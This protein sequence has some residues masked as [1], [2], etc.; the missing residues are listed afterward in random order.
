LIVRNHYSH[1]LPGGT[2][3]SFGVILNSRLLGA[4]T[5]GVGPYLGYKLVNGATPDDAVTL[6]RLWLS[7][8]L[9][10]NSESKV[11]GIALRSLKR[12]TSLKFILAYS[13]PAVGHLGTI[14]QATT[15][16]TPD[17]HPLPR[18][19]ISEMEYCITRVHWLIS[20]AAI[21]YVT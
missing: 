20:W 18:Y 9:P 5:F 1:S 10:R 19:T 13:D 8:E 2:K 7:D 21:Q 4:L 3:L 16:F 12:D 11:L 15:G 6:T 14:Y 17:S